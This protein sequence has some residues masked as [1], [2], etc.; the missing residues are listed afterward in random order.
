VRKRDEQHLDLVAD[1]LANLEEVERFLGVSRSTV[2]K[3]LS[4]G[5]LP[6]CKV[7]GARRVPWAALRELAAAC[8]VGT[9]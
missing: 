3:L 2:Y 1:G 4:S 6:S 5:R 8:L 7:L 9:D